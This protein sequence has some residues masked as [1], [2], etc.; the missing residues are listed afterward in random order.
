MSEKPLALL[1]PYRDEE[2]R[3]NLHSYINIRDRG[4]PP[5]FVGREDILQRLAKDV[6]ECRSNTRGSTCFTRV[7][8]GAPGAGKTSLIEEVQERLGHGIG[9]SKRF[10]DAVVVVSVSG[11]MFFREA[12]VANRIIE[13]CTGE[14]FDVQKERSSSTSAQAAA[15]G[16]GAS[17]GRTTK[18]RSLEQQIQCAGELWKS[19]VDRT[20]INKDDTVLLLLIDEAQSIRGVASESGENHI[21]MN[22]HE[23]SN[24]TRGLKIV[25]VFVGLSDTKS[26]LKNRGISRFP[27][28]SAIS[29][30]SLSREETEELVSGWMRHEPFGF[31]NLFSND[32]IARVSN[33][34]AV[35]SEGWPRHAN[36]YLSELARAVLEHDG[37]DDLTVDLDE[38]LN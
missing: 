35:A 6:E 13:A 31:A 38:V 33:M 19:V 36:T 4:G 30:G 7:I 16:F 11:G 12:F 34:I 20:F 5:V 15:A 24:S 28:A 10:H 18:E 22:L 27:R 21:V 26:V 8:Q 2:A 14:D 23:G 37:S 1:R 25:P 9:K 32:D 29:L 3:A 17:H